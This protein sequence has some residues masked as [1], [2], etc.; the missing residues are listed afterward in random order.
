[1]DDAGADPA[2]L[3]AVIAARVGELRS[4]VNLV[5]VTTAP[6]LAPEEC[7]E[8]LDGL[9]DDGWSDMKVWAPA[10]GS[11]QPGAHQS[12]AR[13]DVRRG[14]QR[15][16]PGG[17]NGELA[18]RITAQVFAVN[19]RIYKFRLVGVE[20][21]VQVLWYAGE[22]SDGYVAHM[23]VGPVSSLRKLS[24]SLLLSD[25]D[26]FAG[27][28]LAFGAP[29]PLA[30]QQGTLTIFPSFLQHAVTPVTSGDR[31]AVVGFVIGP[32]FS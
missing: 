5:D 29:F 19:D 18:A 23:D 24:F 7:A 13:A 17:N 9:D 12:T 8:F 10:T 1:M 31:Y 20:H 6:L 28:D 21:P 16:V 4:N 32:A 15:A 25:P 22:S 30:R 26:T 14:R 11:T 3:A 27:G 2:S